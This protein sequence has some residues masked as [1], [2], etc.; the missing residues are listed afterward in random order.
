[1]SGAISIRSPTW[2]SCNSGI[3]RSVERRSSST[4]P[5]MPSRRWIQA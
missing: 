3:T 1:M 4:D 5:A 2:R